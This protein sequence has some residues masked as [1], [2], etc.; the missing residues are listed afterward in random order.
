[1][2]FLSKIYNYIN[3]RA[4][5]SNISMKI[6]G[7]CISI[8]VLVYV[9]NY[10]RYKINKNSK[11]SEDKR[12]I[13]L[14]IVIRVLMIIAISFELLHYY[15]I[16]S[17]RGFSVEN[18]V[19]F[20]VSVLVAMGYILVISIFYLF[21]LNNNICRGYFYFFDIIILL[22]PI[23]QK[24]IG[25]L[26]FSRT[27]NGFNNMLFS[28]MILFSFLA[29]MLFSFFN[30]YWDRKKKIYFVYFT[31]L[32]TLYFLYKRNLRVITPLLLFLVLV[33]IYEFFKE[34]K[35]LKNNKRQNIISIGFIIIGLVLII[36]MNPIYNVM[37]IEAF[38]IQK[39]PIRY[40]DIDK[41]KLLSLEKLRMIADRFRFKGDEPFVVKY[42]DANK[43]YAFDNG[44][45]EIRISATYGKIESIMNWSEIYNEDNLA[46]DKNKV[47]TSENADKIKRFIKDTGIYDG[48]IK[49]VQNKNTEYYKDFIIYDENEEVIGTVSATEEGE[50]MDY[51]IDY[52]YLM[53]DSKSDS[54][55]A[56]Y[57]KSIDE[58]I[59]KLHINISNLKVSTVYSNSFRYQSINF[60]SDYGYF[61]IDG[62][63]AKVISYRAP[64]EESISVFPESK[65]ENSRS[66][67]KEYA[68]ELN[69]YDLNDF[70]F[71]DEKYDFYR[72]ETEYIFEKEI[73]KKIIRVSIK[74]NNLNELTNFI[75]REYLNPEFY[76]KN[77]INFD[78][79]DALKIVLN[80]YSLLEGYNTKVVPVF[81][82]DNRNNSKLAWQV[83]ITPFKSAEVESYLVFS[84]DG[85]IKPL[86][87]YRVVK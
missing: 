36:L 15:S 64:Y 62:V 76:E 9:Y 65:Y 25:D 61:A 67:A 26:Y 1:M 6:I 39:E 7:L 31:P 84:D 80:N 12:L 38:T 85:K 81:V 42:A 79:M 3:D 60:D 24:T 83:S 52:G 13:V 75:E 71:I 19:M 21:S 23:I 35:F 33:I 18:E 40:M 70:E 55:D 86:S 73:D 30:F 27:Y 11:Y 22:L 20:K 58:F 46:M 72:R 78:K 51:D 47:R 63:T 56:E 8:I 87:D 10:F 50:L 43:V 29:L 5:L 4:L 74:L 34:H 44:V 2:T 77:E 82:V 37:E 54:S 59:D 49:I 48:K 69:N 16:Y 53:E 45:Y 14:G 32:I 41:T 28:K 66:I 17:F 68:K 57:K